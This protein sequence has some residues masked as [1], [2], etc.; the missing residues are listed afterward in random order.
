MGLTTSHPLED[1]MKELNTLAKA[2]LE[3]LEQ[4]VG[5]SLERLKTRRPKEMK[6]QMP[7]GSTVRVKTCV[8]PTMLVVASD[9]S[10]ESA[11]LSIEGTDYLLLVMPEKPREVGPIMAHF[12]PTSVAVETIRSTQRAWLESDPNT[13]GDNKSWHIRFDGDGAKPW[14]G[15][16]RHWAKYRLPGKAS[17]D[18]FGLGASTAK[19]NSEDAIAIAKRMVAAAKG[20][21]PEQVR[22]SID[23]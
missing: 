2:G 4:H 3:L 15:F 20:V 14:N 16:Q 21:R 10:P 6:Y 11:K 9:P 8:D 1:I 7:D 13:K 23:L 19:Q 22:I 17:I 18:H 5:G 12:V